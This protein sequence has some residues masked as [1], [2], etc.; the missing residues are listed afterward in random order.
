MQG[1]CKR[2]QDGGVEALAESSEGKRNEIGVE[3]P[4]Q[5]IAPATLQKPRAEGETHGHRAQTHRSPGMK[6][7]SPADVEMS[8]TLPALIDRVN[9][10]LPCIPE[11]SSSGSA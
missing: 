3:H 8:S 2:G 9:N 11:K 10:L 1:S 4:R 6:N 7:E 5:A